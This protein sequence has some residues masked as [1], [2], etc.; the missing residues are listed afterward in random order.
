MHKPADL[1]V[2]PSRA[3]DTSFSEDQRTPGGS[4]V[5]DMAQNMKIPIMGGMNYNQLKA[6]KKRKEDE[7]RAR[8]A[9]EELEEYERKEEERKAQALMKASFTS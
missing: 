5:K 1:P 8:R 2:A 7:E 4:S 3:T 9:Q 6:E